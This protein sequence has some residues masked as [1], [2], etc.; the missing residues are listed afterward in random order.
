MLKTT[1]CD[2]FGIKYP[3]IQGG[4]AHVA[5]AEL[6]SAV[7]NAGIL[8]FIGAGNAEPDWVKEQIRLTRQQ[9]DKPFGVNIALVSPFAREIIELVIAEKVAVV[10]T[11]AGKPGIYIH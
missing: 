5:T 1:I 10:A 11:V 7:S 8:G 9:T 2:L 6:V 4:M 3:I